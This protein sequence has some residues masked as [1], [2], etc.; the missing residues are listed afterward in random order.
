MW[1]FTVSETGRCK[2]NDVCTVD[3]P[4]APLLRRFAPLFLPTR[5][6][7]EPKPYTGT[8]V[9]FI[10]PR[11]FYGPRGC[12]PHECTESQRGNPAEQHFQD[13]NP[14]SRQVPKAKGRR[15]NGVATTHGATS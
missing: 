13:Q 1:G 4:S 6:V 5:T 9:A 12:L 8:W 10:P 11:S 15:L 2:A 3:F 14:K 7:V